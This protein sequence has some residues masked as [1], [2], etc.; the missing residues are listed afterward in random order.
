MT[1]NTPSFTLYPTL[2]SSY[3]FILSFP[4]GVGSDSIA[5]TL[6]D[7]MPGLA[8]LLTPVKQYQ[9]QLDRLFAFGVVQPFIFHSIC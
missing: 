8:R 2:R 4:S 9:A 6:S 1:G 3:S 7:G 5:T